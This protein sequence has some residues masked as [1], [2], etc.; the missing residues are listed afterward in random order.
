MNL[1][2]Y[3]TW[4]RLNCTSEKTVKS[5]FDNMKRFFDVHE[6][7]NQENVND[8]YL[9]LKD[10]GRKESTLNQLRKSLAKYVEFSNIEID[11][12]KT[13]KPNKQDRNYIT[14]DDLLNKI[15][16]DM[17]Q[18]STS[19]YQNELILL[20]VMFYTGLRKE[21]L[22]R[23]K[24]EHVII[25]ETLIVEGE[26]IKDNYLMIVDT[27]GKVDRKVPFSN[28]LKK[29]IEKLFLINN[30][31]ENLLGITYRQIE[32]VISRINEGLNMKLKPHSFRHSFARYMLVK[33]VDL[34]TLKNLMGHKKI[35]TTEIYLH[36]LNNEMT[37]EI[38]WKIFNKEK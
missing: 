2:Q 35:E 38:C 32:L 4:L 26:K 36:D 23:L 27:K 21:E 17:N 16:P 7:F 11:L 10:S 31:K 28:K 9:N 6:I 30:G 14:E 18:I 3:K 12:P 25:G 29:D 22:I 33:G 5:Y 24:K 34:Y 15:L 20:K 19:N 37:R 8:F 1:E 13:K